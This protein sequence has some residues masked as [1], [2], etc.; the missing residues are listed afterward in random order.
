MIT[1]ANELGFLPGND[2]DRNSAAL[3]SAVDQGGEINVSLPGI[4]DISNPI[5]IGDDTSL[6]FAEGITLRRVP[7]KGG[8]NGNAFI[9]KGAFSRQI[10]K[11]ITLIGLNLDCNGVESTGFGV[12]SR[13]VGLR[14]QVGFIYVKNLRVEKFTCTGLYKKDYGIQISAFK[15]IH[16]E[17]LFIEGKKDGV[18]L[19][20]GSDFIIRNGRFR[21]FDDPIALNAFD[22]SVSNT[23][24][25]W[26]ENGLIENCYDLS[27]DD[28]VGYFCRIL[29]GAWVNW[30]S[31]MEVQHSDTVCHAGNIYR[32]VMNATD[33]KLYKSV[34]PPTH[35]F[36][37]EEY[38]GINWVCTQEGT[39]L[40]CGCRNITLR[41]IHLEKKRNSA[42]AISLNH[43][44]YAQS[45]Y[46]GC[47]PIPH[48]NITID[49]VYI[50]NEV[51]YLLHSNYPSENI[52]LKNT[53]LDRSL[54]G[55]YTDFSRCVIDYPQVE[56]H[57]E[58]VP[59]PEKNLVTDGIHKVNLIQS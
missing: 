46:P 52:T 54:L 30:Y 44:T 10:N 40:D 29:G 1:N 14:A 21:T 15:N 36:G 58:N 51:K 22:Y 41:N 25:G 27:D 4:Y 28:T 45:C 19:G 34:T 42:V 3:Q 26:I 53:D 6:I 59:F 7:C 5:E 39:H 47:R 24:V 50:K 37:V 13:Y 18:H 8:I 55:F 11:N 12:G 56:L 23:H 2:A 17:D 43:D 16:L 32:V 9:N 48:S 33:G 31:G 38:D 35:S 57:T 49:K 20:W